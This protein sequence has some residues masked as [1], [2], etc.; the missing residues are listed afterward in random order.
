MS[1][2]CF[3]RQKIE[4]TNKSIVELLSK[5]IEYLQPNPGKM[6]CVCLKRNFLC[7][8]MYIF[9]PSLSLLLSSVASRA[10]LNM[11]N[12]VSRMRGQV[13]TNG[14]PQ[15]EGLLGDCMLR[16]GHELGENSV[17]GKKFYHPQNNNWVYITGTSNAPEHVYPKW[18]VVRCNFGMK[19]PS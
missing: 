7:S 13:R 14:Y 8:R 19:K 10:K 4:V 5:T 9:F 18:G 3:F 17:F 11:L 1:A 12:T 15:T 6:T 2:F 16:Y